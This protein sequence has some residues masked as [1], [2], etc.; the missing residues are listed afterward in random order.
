M[1]RRQLSKANPPK[2]TPTGRVFAAADVRITPGV[3]SPVYAYGI[4]LQPSERVIEEVFKLN[5]KL[6]QVVRDTGA[7]FTLD[8]LDERFQALWQQLQDAVICRRDVPCTPII[9]KEQW[10]ILY[11]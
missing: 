3:F 8:D 11:V 10:L 1:H 5:A 4:N 7:T 2:Q 6:A 9:A